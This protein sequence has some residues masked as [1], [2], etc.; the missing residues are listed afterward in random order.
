MSG[1]RPEAALAWARRGLGPATVASLDGWTLVTPAGQPAAR[2]PY[3]D[4]VRVLAGRPVGLRMRPALGFFQ[5][6]RQAVVTVHGR[7]WRAVTRWAMWTP[8]EALVTV[9]D[10]APARPIDII[11]AAATVPPEEVDDTERVLRAILRD[12]GRDAPGVLAALFAALGLPGIEVLA[13]LT[14]PTE[15]PGAQTVAP[16]PR[17]A[18]AFDRVVVEENRYRAELGF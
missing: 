17:H 2:P 13:G 11:A 4:A 5:V 7:R 1:C 18:R 16:H 6:G 15:L 3:A 10:L 14:D 9:S 8:G 12:G